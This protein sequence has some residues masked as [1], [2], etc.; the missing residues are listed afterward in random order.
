MDFTVPEE[1]TALRASF[2]AFLDRE[3]RPVEES[4]REE[5]DSPAPD[6]ERLYEAAMAVRRRSA[7]EGFY[8]CYL[9]EEVGGWGVSNLGMALLVEDA[10]RSRD[11]AGHGDPRRSQPVGADA[12]AAGAAR[13]PVGDVPAPGH[14]RGA[15]DVLRAHR[16]GGGQRRPGDPHPRPPRRRRVGDQRHE[17][18][19]HQRRPG[20]LRRGLRGDRR[21]EARPRRHHRVRRAA[22]ASTGSAR[23]SGRSPTRTPPSCGS[24]VHGS[25]PTTSSARWAAASRPR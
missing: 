20:R 13:A 9:P 10:A 1:L 17:A 4:L 18:L 24:T 12:A 3:V 21:R 23:R 15:D 22:R 5:L 16:A 25:P 2:A 6:R 14:A 8:A 19:H 7:E 11:A